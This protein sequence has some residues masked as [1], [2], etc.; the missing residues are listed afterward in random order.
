MKKKIYE[1][2]K[3]AVLKIL[4]VSSALAAM[5]VC[6]SNSLNIYGTADIWIG[7]SKPIAT[8]N[9]N[10]MQSG[11]MQT[12]YFGLSGSEDLGSNLKAVFALE[13]YFRI[14]T[15]EMGRYEGDDF[16]SRSAYVG[17]KG[18]LGRLVVGR[19]T[20]PYFTSTALFNPLGASFAFSPAIF[21]SYGP[22][23]TRV[24]APILGDSGWDQSALYTSPDLGGFSFNLQYGR[25]SA[26][27]ASGL[28]L[29]KENNAQKVGGNVIYSNGPFSATVALQRLNYAKNAGDLALKLQDHTYKLNNQKA[30]LAGAAYDFSSFKIYAQYQYIKNNALTG[31][32][33][34]INGAQVGLKVPTGQVGNILA[35]YAYAKTTGAIRQNRNTWAVAYQY[36]LSKST[37]IY[38]AY[39]RDSVSHL[40][41]GNNVGIGIKK[42][43]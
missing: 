13:S 34:K 25:G 18:E 4:L 15:G 16:F 21:H 20:S 23:G 8:K 37:E 14:N 39:L 12:S 7:G 11:G 43:F 38:T 6:A 26:H 36:P 9:S 40:E 22:N 17:L 3:S 32:N 19:T 24:S 28:N 33:I 2:E 35:S 31:K 1:T 41:H 30:L 29:D 5:P 10:K 42:T 27:K